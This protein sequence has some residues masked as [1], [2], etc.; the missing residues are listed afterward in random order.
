MDSSFGKRVRELREARGLT[1]PALAAR[2]HMN[3]KFLS[4]IEVSDVNVTLATINKLAAALGVPVA[5]LFNTSDQPRT[6]DR[7]VALAVAKSIV[8]NADDDKARRFRL[9]VESFR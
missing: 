6:D 5:E 1:Q 7:K 4:R 8:E 3:V 2:V 9:T